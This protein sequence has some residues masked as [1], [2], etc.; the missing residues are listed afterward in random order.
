MTKPSLTSEELIIIFQGLKTND[1]KI[2]INDSSINMIPKYWN[3]V[4][5]LNF[6]PAIAGIYVLTQQND[7]KINLGCFFLIALSLYGIHSQLIFLNKVHI[8]I[9]EERIV[10][11]PN[12]I[13]R[14][15]RKTHTI[16]FTDI[17]NINFCSNGFGSS[18]VRYIII[19][20]LKNTQQMKIIS[21]AKRDDAAKIV[22]ALLKII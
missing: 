9:K 6:I 3:Y 4:F 8:S 5:I 11:T 1:P 20:K 15:F 18:H 22:K 19:F 17:Q 12:I 13:E 2:K 7:L 10:V 16:N 21:S 14:L